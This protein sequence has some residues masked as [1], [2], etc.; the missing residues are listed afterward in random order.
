MKRPFACVGLSM[1]FSLVFATAFH[2]AALTAAAVCF[3]ISVGF[4]IARFAFNKKT[5]VAAVCCLSAFCAIMG[6]CGAVRFYIDPISQK[7]DGI[8]ADFSG[9][10]ISN[11]Y[12]KGNNTYFTVKTDLING[13][14]VDYKIN[15]TVSQTVPMNIYDYVEVHANLSS[16]YTEGYGYASYYG[17][18]H[19]F[20][21]TYLNYYNKGTYK[22]THSEERPFYAV[23]D[24]LR[25]KIGEK[26][27]TY[28]SYDEASLCIAVM[29]GE[30]SFLRDEV[31]GNF[32]NLGVSHMLVVSGMHLSLA[33]AI[34]YAVI[35]KVIKNRT[36]SALIQAAGVTAFAALS[37][38]G[39]SVRRA[40][41]MTLIMIAARMIRNKADALNSLGFAAAVMCFDPLCVGDVGMLWSFSC[42]LSLVVLPNVINKSLINFFSSFSKKQLNEK[43]AVKVLSPLSAAL[44]AFVGSLPFFIFVTGSFSPYTILVNLITVPFTGIIIVCGGLSVMLFFMGIKILAYPFMYL[45]GITAKYLIFVTDKFSKLP[46]ACIDI[47]RNFAVI[48]L[49]ITIMLF[50]F[51][52]FADKKKKYRRLFVI[53]SIS[54]LIGF[55][56]FDIALNG[57]KV[58]LSVLDVGNGITVAVKNQRDAVVLN[59]YGEKY[60][61]GT[62]EKEFSDYRKIAC[63]VDIPPYKGGYDYSRKIINDF[64][65]DKVLVSTEYAYETK[66][67]YRRYRGLNVEKIGRNETFRLS[68]GISL[69]LIRTPCGTW[70]YLTIYGNEILLCPMNS[71]YNMLPPDFSCPDIIIFSNIPKYFEQNDKEL[72]IV[73]AY[74]EECTEVLGENVMATNGNGKIDFIFSNNGSVKINQKYTGG[75]TRYAE[76]Q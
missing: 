56:S 7:Y 33:A 73:S 39:F 15:V 32:K 51:L 11:P 74:G 65:V 72:I 38:F 66:Y 60:Q 44:A 29:T 61:Y 37:G 75:V 6:Y 27:K 50:I 5:I 49:V 2:T 14:E 1:L 17:A 48:W 18:R 26:L 42:T 28:L 34:L 54:V 53:L 55:Y 76:N 9:T 41:L 36:I 13:E 69:Q 71:N 67:C 46:Y 35:S 21:S 63:L 12:T 59:S 24:D 64:P 19:I 22:V 31:Y 25:F 40:F 58:T 16:L 3:I 8:Q 30:R 52:H 4:F 62:I 70:E 47:S 68:S 45:S 43:F 20:L 57:D 10:I 23:F